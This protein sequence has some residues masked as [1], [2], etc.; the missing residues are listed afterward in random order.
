MTHPFL[1]R[2]AL[3][4]LLLAPTLAGA[5]VFTVN[6]TED[7]V[8]AKPGD[9][10]CS[11]SLTLN[12]SKH[13]LCSL[14]AAIMEGNATPANIDV[15]VRLFPGEVYT[16]TLGGIEEDNAKS[17]D[18]DILRSMTIG[19]KPGEAPRAIVDAN[20]IS[21]AFD[22]FSKDSE[23]N[24]VEITNGFL[25]NGDGVAILARPA[26]AVRLVDLDVHG[27]H[28]GDQ[29]VVRCAVESPDVLL[30]S[31]V[32]DNGA[33]GVCSRTPMSIARSTIDN[34]T[35]SGISVQ[36]VG[37]DLLLHS[38]TISMNGGVG[39]L[40]R[41]A[42]AQIRNSTIVNNSEGQ[43][44]VATSINVQKTLE[45]VGS[46]IKQDNALFLACHISEILG[47]LTFTSAWNLYSDGSCVSDTPIDKSLHNA[48]IDLSDLGDWGG[49]APT[50][51][52]LAESVAIDYA[53]ADICDELGTDQR[54]LPR[55]V[56]KNGSPLPQCD[57]GAVELQ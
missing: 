2:W 43:L 15:F 39:I 37:S 45:V 31:H 33:V 47:N 24:G 49:P 4:A 7:K 5:K 22:L 3:S 27:N 20:H 13:P 51:L 35:K 17:G 6:L 54:G 52:P 12:P 32:H 9:G 46:I 41:D 16:L 26:S 10:I 34:N 23:I 36:N 30:D 42:N 55:P 38:S 8:D 25:A 48:Q 50:H 29:R 57:I 56:S 1:A 53:P 18:L 11:V 44:H 40:L 28:S 19:I 21:R 14:R